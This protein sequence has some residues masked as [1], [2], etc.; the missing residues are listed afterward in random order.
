M[1]TSE[2]RSLYAYAKPAS[3]TGGRSIQLFFNY[4]FNTF[5]VDRF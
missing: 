1:Y 4:V 3:K 2:R 5:W